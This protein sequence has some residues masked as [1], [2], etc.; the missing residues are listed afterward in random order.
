M[1]QATLKWLARFFFSPRRTIGNHRGYHGDH[2]S[3]HVCAES[4]VLSRREV[5]FIGLLAEAHIFLNNTLDSFW[6]SVYMKAIIINIMHSCLY[7]SRCCMRL[8][9][10]VTIN[11]QNWINNKLYQYI[12]TDRYSSELQFEKKG[13]LYDFGGHFYFIK[14]GSY[15]VFRVLQFYML[16]TGVQL[17]K[18]LKKYFFWR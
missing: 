3:G 10:D 1:E 18:T 15:F 17:E 8:P 16:F 6:P 2:K 13:L 9:N 12:I 5:E 7:T 14:F 11:T 4:G